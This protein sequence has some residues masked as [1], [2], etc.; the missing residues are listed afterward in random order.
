MSLTSK[1]DKVYVVHYSPLTDRRNYILNFFNRNNI[2]NY[3]FRYLFDHQPRTDT[4]EN[5]PDELVEYY[6][7]DYKEYFLSRDSCVKSTI[8]IGVK[9]IQIYDDILKNNYNNWCLIL[10]DD[11]TFNDDFVEKIN[12]FMNY[13]PTDADYLDINNYS[14]NYDIFDYKKPIDVNN[15][16]IPISHTKTGCSYLVNKSFCSNV[17]PYVIP[18]EV[19]MDHKINR[20][21]HKYD[22]INMY[23]SIFPLVNHGSMNIYG[24]SY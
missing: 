6:Y 22:N 17:M 20:I 3:E 14:F 4:V 8:N 9:H 15:L 24:R 5:L 12:L 13:V 1:I 11:A 7:E 2:T 10:E 16:W 18:F 21:K 23:W 19:T